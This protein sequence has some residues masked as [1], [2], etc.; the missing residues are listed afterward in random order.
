MLSG[1]RVKK[2]VDGAKDAEAGEGTVAQSKPGGVAAGD[3]A[4]VGL[5]GLGMMGEDCKRGHEAGI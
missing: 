2:W 3:R 1:E 5:D 4:P